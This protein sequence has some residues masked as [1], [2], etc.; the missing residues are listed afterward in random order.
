M[1]KL[2]FKGYPSLGLLLLR[3]GIG[4]MMMLGHGLD[5]LANFGQMAGK[6][7]DPIGLGSEVSLGLAVLAEFFC[8]LFVLLGLYM[9]LAL[10]PLIVTMLVAVLLIHGDDP[11][12]KQ[13]TALLYLVPYLTLLITGAGNYSLD[14]RLR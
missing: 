3:V 5:K 2:L 10:I 8:S 11:F 6:F 13:E 7:P 4:L 14:Y 12:S 1:R 9:R